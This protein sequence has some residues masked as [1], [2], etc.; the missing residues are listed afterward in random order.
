MFHYASRE[1]EYYNYRINTEVKLMD[2]GKCSS[3]GNKPHAAHLDG[4]FK[5]SRYHKNQ[6]GL[7][8]T[9]FFCI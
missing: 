7:Y 9:K 1:F 3:C 5:L 2:P 8:N 6:K 4:N